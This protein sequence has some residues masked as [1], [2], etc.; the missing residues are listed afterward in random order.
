MDETETW[1]V[2]KHV[3]DGSAEKVEVRRDRVCLCL[4][5]AEDPTIMETLDIHVLDEPLLMERLKQMSQNSTAQKDTSNAH[6][7]PDR[8][9]QR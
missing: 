1:I 7:A 2:C 4:T 9:N 8:P 3:M 6:S 5:C